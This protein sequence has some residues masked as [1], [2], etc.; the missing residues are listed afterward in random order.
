MKTTNSLPNLI[1]L[2]FHDWMAGQRNASRHTI[3]S[4]RDTWRLFLRFVAQRRQE[5]VA[6]LSLE[7]LSDKEV[8]AFLDHVERDRGAT[9]ATR[10]CRLAALH[11]FF[12][13]VADREP[14]AA[15]QCAA[16]LRIPSKR[17]PKRS[18]SYLESEELSVLLNQPDRNTKLGQRDHLLLALL[19]NTGARISEALRLC[20]RDI[21]LD[22]PPQVRF[23]GKGRKERICPLWPETANL[24]A[25]FFKRNSVGPE[26]PIFR[27]RYDQP[28]R[29]AGARFRLRRYVQSAVQ[30]V[31]RL[32]DKHV[33][34]HTFRHTAAVHLLA[35]GVD[36]AVV[37]S[38][39]GHASLDTTNIYAQANLETKRK[40]LEKVD[41]KLRPGK[42]PRWKKGTALLN[43]LDSL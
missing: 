32:S 26:E 1:H 31:P 35:S 43:W 28:L 25:A 15:G 30:R 19:Y 11:S 2:F 7:D 20:W 4:Y 39:M 3:L 36:V 38:W 42:A 17:S 21:R 14:L 5:D 12:G 37:R 22:A 29:A 34:P 41:G 23:Y 24:L 6:R 10:N 9:I 18:V 8:L 13:F 16:I 27:N 33:S 40:A